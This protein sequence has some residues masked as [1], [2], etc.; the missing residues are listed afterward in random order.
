VLLGTKSR[1]VDDNGRLIVPSKFREDLGDEAIISVGLNER[2]LFLFSVAEWKKFDE[3]VRKLPITKKDEQGFIRWFLS[4]ASHVQ[5][6]QQGR[7][8]IPQDLREWAGI[9]K[10]AVI[11]GVS[12]RLEIWDKAK[13]KDF[14]KEAEYKFTKRQS[15]SLRRFP[16]I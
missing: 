8:L 9:E 13:W 6:D 7:L 4:S 16:R 12:S 11:V 2:C 10:D 14:Y 15:T 1:T 5:I 3:K